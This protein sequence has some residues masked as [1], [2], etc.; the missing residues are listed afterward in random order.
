MYTPLSDIL[1]SDIEDELSINSDYAALTEPQKLQLTNS[2]QQEIADLYIAAGKSDYKS[3]NLTITPIVGPG[4]TPFQVQAVTATNAPVEMLTLA[5]ARFLIP[6][7]FSRR[8]KGMVAARDVATGDSHEWEFAVLIKNVGGVT[9]IVGNPSVGDLFIDG[10]AAAWT[11]DISADDVHDALA[12]TATG[13]NGK[14]IHWVAQMIYVD[15]G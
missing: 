8:V 14:A 4:T 7:G 1:Q 11:F 9:T 13:E 5:G 10:G 2:A 3:S 12:L 6:A 15:A